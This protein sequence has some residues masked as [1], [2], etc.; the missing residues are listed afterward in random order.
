MT[1]GE[2]LLKQLHK[3][4]TIKENDIGADERMDK[5]LMHFR[6]K[7]YEIKEL[8]HF[9]LFDM[10]GMFGLMKMETAVLSVWKKDVPLLNADVIA[11]SG[12]K[13]VMAEFYDTLLKERGEDWEKA[14]L[15]VKEKDSDLEDYT[16]G[17]HWYDSLLYSCRYAKK[18]KA[19]ETRADES[20][21]K[22]LDIFLDHLKEAEDCEEEAKKE[23]IRSFAQGLLDHGGPAVDQVKKMFGEEKAKTLILKHMYGIE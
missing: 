3:R 14:C 13:T 1:N 5:G 12:K 2:Y 9:C 21:R 11:V 7:S 22:I 4:Y 20:V 16:S 6:V 10:T 8:G 18:T 17:E 19:K 23:K 15:S